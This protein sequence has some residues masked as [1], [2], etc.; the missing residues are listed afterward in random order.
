MTGLTRPN[1]IAE[2]SPHLPS[3]VPT[4]LFPP[5]QKKADVHERPD[6]SLNTSNPTM[7]DTAKTI[8]LIVA[9][10]VIFPWGVYELVK[11]ATQRV[12][13]AFVYPAQNCL[14][15]RIS[16]QDLEILKI[17][18]TPAVQRM[19]HLIHRVTLEKNGVKYRG[20]E[21]SDPTTQNNGNWA[22]QGAGNSATV[23]EYLPIIN[24][25]NLQAG[26]NTL[27]IDNPGVGNSEG[28]STS[29]TMGEVQDLAM[30]YLETVKNAKK[31]AFIGH[32]LSGGAMSK[33]VECHTFKEGV[34]YLGI[35][36]MTF[37]SLSHVAKKI[38]K[39]SPFSC[40][41]S[42]VRPLIYWTGLEMDPVRTSSI[43]AKKGIPEHI[44]NR[45]RV[46]TEK[47]QSGYFH[48]RVICAKASLGHRLYKEN[49]THL[50]TSDHPNLDFDHFS[51]EPFNLTAKILQQWTNPDIR[52]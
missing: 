29:A 22:L 38:I 13:M 19:R 12:I 3:T 5:I 50:K 47:N 2:Q 44:I 18:K 45:R 36:Q 14:H 51:E 42:F 48:D 20:W 32:S 37:G 43:L 6:F 23:A 46:P 35:Q 17:L 7:W 16:N 1:P 11:Y 25:K 24:D 26:F 33:M 15:K 9:K 34:Q 4:F 40:F 31:V 8:L 10:I 49:I 27:L 30:I 39:A 28:T 21:I 41:R 52:D